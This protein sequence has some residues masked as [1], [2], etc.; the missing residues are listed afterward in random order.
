[1]S[2]GLLLKWKVFIIPFFHWGDDAGV[3]VW[4][5]VKKLG[6]IPNSL[7]NHSSYFYFYFLKKFTLAWVVSRI[8]CWILSELLVLVSTFGDICFRLSA[9]HPR[10]LPRNLRDNGVKVL[11]TYCTFG[12]RDVG[13]WCYIC[14]LP[15]IMSVQIEPSWSEDR[16]GKF[17]APIT[18][19]PFWVA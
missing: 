2:W 12:A 15:G 1:M 3:D 10:T 9:Y 4:L 14:V 7:H 16:G 5:S 6:N 8:G 19:I 17:I 11:R 13:L 18:R